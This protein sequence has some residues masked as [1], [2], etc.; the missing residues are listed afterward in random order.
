MKCPHCGYDVRRPIFVFPRNERN[1]RFA[2]KGTQFKVFTKQMQ[3][4]KV[5]GL[6]CVQRY[7]VLDF[8]EKNLYVS[9]KE[10]KGP[11]G[12]QPKAIFF[13]ESEI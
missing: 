5:V 2:K 1:D 12:E 3:N 13:T 8:D 4:G 10:R 7:E 6:L 9:Y 11:H